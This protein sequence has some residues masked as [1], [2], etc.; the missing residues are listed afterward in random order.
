MNHFHFIMVHSIFFRVLKILNKTCRK[1][2]LVLTLVSIKL[3]L[4]PVFRSE[5]RSFPVYLHCKVYP[6]WWSVSMLFWKRIVYL[7][8]A[9]QHGFCGTSKTMSS[10][11]LLL[12]ATESSHP[13]HIG[14]KVSLLEKTHLWSYPNF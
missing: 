3:C 4:N 14:K 7:Q 6:I 5:T 13:W 8:C 9:I 12:A 1:H 10:P 11:T 2:L